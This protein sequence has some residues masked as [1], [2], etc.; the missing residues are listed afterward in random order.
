MPD[1]C[2]DSPVTK[3]IRYQRYSNARRVRFDINRP[4]PHTSPHAHVEELVDGKWRKSG[5]IYPTDVPPR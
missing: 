4:A 1:V 3:R 5:P 2:P